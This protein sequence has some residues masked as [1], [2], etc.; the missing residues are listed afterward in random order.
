MPRTDII[1]H[2]YDKLSG[3]LTQLFSTGKTTGTTSFSRFHLELFTPSE[4]A[5]TRKIYRPFRSFGTLDLACFNTIRAPKNPNYT[6][7]EFW[8]DSDKIVALNPSSP[9]L[10]TGGLDCHSSDAKHFVTF[11]AVRSF[12]YKFMARISRHQ[13]STWRAQFSLLSESYIALFITSCWRYCFGVLVCSLASCWLNNTNR[14][15]DDRLEEHAKRSVSETAHLQAGRG[16]STNTTWPR[17]P[18]TAGQT[19][20]G[21]E[22][23]VREAHACKTHQG[24]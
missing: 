8:Y 6:A 17:G 12:M 15:H 1:R 18:C 3:A 13:E 14:K 21:H 22:R 9:F 11:E 4:C 20:H 2:F 7:R 5:R 16:V 19:T 10:S 24:R 23:V